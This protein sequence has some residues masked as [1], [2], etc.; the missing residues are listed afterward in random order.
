[1]LMDKYQTLL[2]AWG[3]LSIAL[4]DQ[5]EES[6]ASEEVLSTLLTELF[7]IKT[8]LEQWGSRLEDELDERDLDRIAQAAQRKLYRGADWRQ[9]N[10]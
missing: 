5:R 1:M 10:E 2:D 6:I 3:D 7:A 9:S 4:D 8:L